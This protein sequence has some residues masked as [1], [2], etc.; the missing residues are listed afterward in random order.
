MSVLPFLPDVI[1]LTCLSYCSSL[2]SVFL[3]LRLL[4]TYDAKAHEK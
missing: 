4:D 1:L 2:N 3:F